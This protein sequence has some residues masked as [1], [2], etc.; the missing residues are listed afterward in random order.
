[1]VVLGELALDGKV[2]SVRGVLPALIAAYKS[3]VTRAI[4]PAANRSEAALMTQMEI[5]TFESLREV[6][7]WGRTGEYSVVQ[8][9]ELEPTDVNEYLDFAD[10]A[11]QSKARFAAEVAASGGHHLLLIGPPGTGKTMIAS[12]IPTIL[13]ALSI[14]QAS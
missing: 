7:L 6:L 5:L 10:V 8:E 14:D 11:G 12:R 13:P 1:M 4:V 9:L 3:G 2:R